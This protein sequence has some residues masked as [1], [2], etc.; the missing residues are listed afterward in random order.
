MAISV[1]R[2]FQHPANVAEEKGQLGLYGISNEMIADDAVAV[3]EHI[4]E[5]NDLVDLVDLRCL[6]RIT[7]R[8]AGKRLTDDLELA[9]ST[10][11]RRSESAE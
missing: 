5:R 2:L 4:S 6:I 10:P 3:N 8:K 7:S 1:S 9:R 11:D